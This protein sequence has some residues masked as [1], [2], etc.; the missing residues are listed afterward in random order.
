MKIT[1]HMK[2]YVPR[3]NENPLSAH[4]VTM[5][6]PDKVSGFSEYFY[7]RIFLNL[8]KLEYVTFRKFLSAS[9]DFPFD[10][11]KTI[12]EQFDEKSDGNS[13]KKA[14]EVLRIE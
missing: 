7:K 10:F 12:D 5:T 3:K 6:F 1:K 14:L 9:P 4:R 8:W 2:K 13:R 11:L